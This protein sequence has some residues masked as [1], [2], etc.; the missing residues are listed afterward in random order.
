M[1]RGISEWSNELGRLF[2]EVKFNAVLTYENNVIA[3][4]KTN[5]KKF[6]EYLSSYD[7]YED[8]TITLLD[9]ELSGI[10][11]RVVSDSTQCAET[12]NKYFAYVF[13]NGS[14]DLI[15]TNSEP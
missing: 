14:T 2:E 12:L 11:H 1:T 5:P 7:K 8:K 6:Y 4:K 15:N 3:N 9:G 10:T 13:C